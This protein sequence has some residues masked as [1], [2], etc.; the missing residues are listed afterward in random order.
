MAGRRHV[1]QKNER[2]VCAPDARSLRRG[3]ASGARAP[4]PAV[5]IAEALAVDLVALHV[6]RGDKA[7][8]REPEEA[9]RAI[10]ARVTRARKKLLETGGAD[11]NRR[12]TY[13]LAGDGRMLS[14]AERASVTAR[15]YARRAASYLVTLLAGGMGEPLA[16]VRAASYA[17]HQALAD[18]L[19]DLAFA[20]DPRAGL[21]ISESRTTEKGSKL[22]NSWP[23]IG[24][25]LKLAHAATTQA[26]LELLTAL[27]LEERATAG[28]P[29]STPPELAARIDA[30][31]ARDRER[32]EEGKRILAE[33][34][35]SA[36]RAAIVVEAS[37]SESPTR[38]TPA[39][40][41]ADVPP[42]GHARPPEAP[43][44]AAPPPPPPPD[45]FADLLHLDPATRL[46]E[47]IAR[48]SR[49]RSEAQIAKDVGRAYRG[50]SFIPAWVA[51]AFA[52]AG[53]KS[54]V[55]FMVAKLGFAVGPE[56][57]P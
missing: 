43:A 37:A 16:L 50:P 35:A 31:I 33:R 8:G 28:R 32:A 11:L 25:V 34:A 56:V 42:A 10:E 29:A 57:S 13:A 38:R 27:D 23:A 53:R 4:T 55:D 19:T 5:E 9:V 40:Q 30:I 1:R 17:K 46:R 49:W 44:P 6:A 22:T 15:P 20:A 54:E 21:A 36:E 51:A 3:R 26:R 7:A 48:A 2:V 52:Q 14:T 12:V 41:P 24:D 47:A 45:P 39:R 18:L